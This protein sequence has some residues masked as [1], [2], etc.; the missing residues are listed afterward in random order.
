MVPSMQ[1]HIT[2]YCDNSGAVAKSKEPRTHKKGKHIEHKYHLI[3]DIMQRGDVMVTKI[4]SAD[5]LAVLLQ[6][7]YQLRLLISM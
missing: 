5:N 1:L 7:A 4:A 3:Q 6:R 2:L